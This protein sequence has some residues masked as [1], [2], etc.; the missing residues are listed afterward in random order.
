[1]LRIRSLSVLKSVW[2]QFS[3]VFP[4]LSFFSPFFIDF[5]F[6]YSHCPTFPFILHPSFFWVVAAPHGTLTATLWANMRSRVSRNGSGKSATTV[7]LWDRIPAFSGD[8]YWLGI[9][10]WS[11][12][13]PG[14]YPSMVGSYLS[15][16]SA[17]TIW[18]R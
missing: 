1:M 7:I 11:V 13:S 9:Y 3:R 16:C 12:Y 8:G 2:I 18:L 14:W 10:L 15:P 17:R 6:F 4:S 5:F